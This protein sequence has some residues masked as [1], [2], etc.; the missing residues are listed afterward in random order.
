MFKILNVIIICIN[1]NIKIKLT[2]KRL[3]PYH[4]QKG[5]RY[6]LSI[7]KHYSH[8]YFIVLKNNK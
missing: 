2:W 1:I 3:F 4:R 5:R 7:I 6:E 8:S